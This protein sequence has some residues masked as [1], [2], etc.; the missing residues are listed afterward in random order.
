MGVFNPKKN[1]F[2]TYPQSDLTMAVLLERLNERPVAIQEYL[3]AEEKHQD[4]NT[5]LHAYIKFATDGIKL[6]EAPSYFTV[7]EKSGDY[8]P[9]RSCK[10]VIKYVKKEGNYLCN[11]DLDT[12]LGKKG[13][14]QV[15]TIRSKSAKQALEDGD[16][17]IYAIKH[18]NLA[19]SILC[20]PYEHDDTRGIWLYG[21]PGVGKSRYVREN[22]PSLYLK[23]QNKWFDGYEGE[24]AILIDD[25]D[26]PGKCLSH[27]LKI[28]TDRYACSG[29]IKG[30]TVN[31][32]HKFF[33]ITSNYAI[34]QIF[35]DDDILVRAL[36]RRF[37]E[38]H[39]T[40]ESI[41]PLSQYAAGFNPG[42]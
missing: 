3:I 16:I 17:N 18:Y 28:W 2:L 4:G 21:P 24:E 32:R 35:D 9:T 8:Q 13:K 37:Q 14:L 42:P 41:T 6:S 33:I 25:F 36:K 15:S 12:Y 40:E 31:L 30:G 34:D 10:A 23:A 38:V 26:L 27:Y 20:E 29:E 39:M 1:W 5:H 19:R 7:S 11:F 22:H